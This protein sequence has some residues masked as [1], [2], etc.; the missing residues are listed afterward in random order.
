MQPS[1]PSVIM[2][3]LLQHQSLARILA[4]NVSI[5]SGAAFDSTLPLGIPTIFSQDNGD[6]IMVRVGPNQPALLPIPGVAWGTANTA[7][8]IQHNLGRIPIGY[9]VVRKYQ[10]C[11][12]YDVGDNVGWSK[13]EIVLLN[14]V[15]DA[16][17]VLY[18]F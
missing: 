9:Y 14:T 16:D 18:I 1:K 3:N 8:T 17:T 13:T 7:I 11:D 6:G 12:V 10:A 2:D 5:G 15:A 4:A